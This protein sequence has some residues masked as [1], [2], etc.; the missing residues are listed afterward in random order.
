MTPEHEKYIRKH[1]AVKTT[2]EIGRKLGLP[3]GT[4]QSFL[5]R[6]GWKVSPE[7]AKER[8]RASRLKNL[9]RDA[10][11]Y[12]I[13]DSTI[14]ANYLTMPSKTLAAKIGKSDVYLRHRLKELGLIIPPE[15]IE[16]RKHDS[17]LKPGAIPPNKGKKQT[18]YMSPEQIERTKSTRF[19]KGQ[20]I[21]N[22]MYDGA[23]SIR[24]D[25]PERNG[26]RP[27]KYIRLSKGKWKELQLHNWE[28]VNGP[29]P[30]GYI[31]A[32]Q[33]GDTL[34]CNPDNWKSITMADNVIRNSIHRYPAELKQTIRILKK[35]ERKIN[36]KQN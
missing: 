10:K 12:H 29:V 14:K 27:I 4:V 34:N 36:E 17:R 21:H 30:D 32:C 18:D 3:K 28:K 19:K 33:D 25:H 16:Q 9:A 2:V 23:I 20:K 24:H 1:I 35:L 6:E 8:R 11:K 15:I 13:G 22:E 5:S 7:I 26:G 31:L